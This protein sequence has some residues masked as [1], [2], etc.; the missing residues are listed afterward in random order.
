[1]VVEDMPI[2]HMS[3]GPGIGHRHRATRGYS[4]LIDTPR[5]REFPWGFGF[6]VSASLGWQ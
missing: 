4:A 5:F 3:A 1:M 2:K 6:G